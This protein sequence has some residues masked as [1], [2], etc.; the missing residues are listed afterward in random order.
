MPRVFRLCLAQNL[1]GNVR[2]QSTL[3]PSR[4]TL[5]QERW[6]VETD[7]SSPVAAAR[8][9]HRKKKKKGAGGGESRLRS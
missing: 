4:E 3:S 8:H 1:H 2:K 6:K 9:V 5:S 7:I